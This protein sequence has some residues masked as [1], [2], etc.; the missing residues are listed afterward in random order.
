[1]HCNIEIISE[2]AVNIDSRARAISTAR[3]T[4]SPFDFNRMAD[5]V[6]AMVHDS[7]DALVKMDTGLARQVMASDD[8]IDSMHK[9]V[10]A[11]LGGLIRENPELADLYIQY[12]SVSRNLERVADHATNIAEDVIYM[13]D[14]EIVRHG[15]LA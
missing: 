6:K 13:I 11:R 2:L 10:Y 5:R 12:I 9:D 1:M 4:V 15:V 14:G 7:L 8:E 3:Q